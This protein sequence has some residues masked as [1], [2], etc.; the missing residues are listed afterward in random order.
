MIWNPPSAELSPESPMSP[1]RAVGN[2]V[3]PLDA[4]AHADA[5]DMDMDIIEA[6]MPLELLLNLFDQA[7][8]EE[9]RQVNGEIMSLISS[10]GGNSA[11]YR[12]ERER[13]IRAV[14]SET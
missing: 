6:D 14:V 5:P 8:R 10:L 2:D 4:Q 3:E 11:K 13:S 1:V 7:T 9:A 12:R